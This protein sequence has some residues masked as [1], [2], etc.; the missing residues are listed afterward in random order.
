MNSPRNLLRNK[1]KKLTQ[2]FVVYKKQQQKETQETYV[3]NKNKNHFPK[4]RD[5]KKTR[6]LKTYDPQKHYQMKHD[7]RNVTKET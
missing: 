1:H 7:Q 2:A 5:L 3:S 6:D 4:S